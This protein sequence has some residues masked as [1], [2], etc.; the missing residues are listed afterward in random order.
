MD[1]KT[2]PAHRGFYMP[3]E[4]YPHECCWMQ[5]PHEISGYTDVPTWSNFDVEK[6]RVAWSNV[7]K[8]ISNFENVK[9]IVNPADVQSAKVLLKDKVQII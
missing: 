2:Y 8:A 4:W 6:G 7:A 5:W 9:M 1:T 3:A